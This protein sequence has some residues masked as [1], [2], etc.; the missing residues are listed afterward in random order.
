M[1]SPVAYSRILFSFPLLWDLTYFYLA[2]VLLKQFIKKHWHEGDEA[3]EH[4]AVSS[5]EKVFS[6][7]LFTSLSST[8]I[9]ISLDRESYFT[10]FTLSRTFDYE[11]VMYF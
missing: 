11:F 5:D 1:V 9:C 10:L 6:V 8:F 3:F 2:A 4:P 7:V